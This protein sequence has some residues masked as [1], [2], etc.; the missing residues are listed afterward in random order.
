MWCVLLW[1]VFSGSLESG[2]NDV[3]VFSPHK[4]GEKTSLNELPY[5]C[6]AGSKIFVWKPNS[7]IA[8]S[9]LLSFIC[10]DQRKLKYFPPFV[11]TVVVFRVSSWI[12]TAG[13]SWR[14]GFRTVM[15]LKSPTC[16]RSTRRILTDAIT[17][18]W[19]TGSGCLSRVCWPSSP[20]ALSWVSSCSPKQ[21]NSSVVTDRCSK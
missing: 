17:E 14:K 9:E 5:L 8:G 21:P 4:H 3:C 16:R 10:R 11:S 7:S 2:S 19:P 1:S 20:L 15:L 13:S 12:C 6:I 18:L